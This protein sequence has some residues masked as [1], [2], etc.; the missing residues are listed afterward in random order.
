LRYT[1][2]RNNNNNN[3]FT[4][5]DTSL[6]AMITTMDAK[7]DTIMRTVSQLVTDSTPVPPKLPDDISLPVNSVTELEAVE[8]ALIENSEV[9]KLYGK[10]QTA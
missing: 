6:V 5:R 1:N 4:A 8:K 2:G 9:K 10:C 3:V 7:L